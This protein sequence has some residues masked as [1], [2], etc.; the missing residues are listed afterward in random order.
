MINQIIKALGPYIRKTDHRKFMVIYYSDG[1]K[2]T[3]LYSRYLMEQKMNRELDQDEIVD[4]INGDKFDDRIENLQII[5][6]K[7]N[8]AK[9][10]KD[11]PHWKAP[12]QIYICPNC[13][14]SFEK[15]SRIVNYEL[16]RRFFTKKSGPFCS[17][18]CAGK[19]TKGG[20]HKYQHVKGL[21]SESAN[22]SVLKTGGENLVGSSPT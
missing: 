3:T 11:N 4:H 10:F 6:R 14:K 15:N 7:E 2:G 16:H 13:G 20:W 1:S 19:F 17:K 12:T 5:S 18:S 8:S 22:E 21:V 9:V